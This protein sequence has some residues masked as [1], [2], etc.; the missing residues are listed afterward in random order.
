MAV[1]VIVLV[2]VLITVPLIIL[3]LLKGDI[4]LTT[5]KEYAPRVNV[6]HARKVALNTLHTNN[7]YNEN[8]TLFLSMPRIKVFWRNTLLLVAERPSISLST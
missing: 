7:L 2:E 1:G 4:N 5:D 6:S 3:S 8:I